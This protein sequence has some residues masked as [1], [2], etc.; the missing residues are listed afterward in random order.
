M[1]FKIADGTVAISVP[2]KAASRSGLVVRI[3][4]AVFQSS[5]RDSYSRSCEANIIEATDEP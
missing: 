2:M 1:A 3:D 5:D 4:A